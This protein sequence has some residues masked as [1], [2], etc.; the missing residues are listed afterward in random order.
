MKIVGKILKYSFFAVILFIIGFMTL[1][2]FTSGDTKTAKSFMWTER[3]VNSY[4]EAPDKFKVYVIDVPREYTEDG[5]FRISNV[6]YAESDENTAAQLQFTV[7]WNNST[8]EYLKEDFDLAEAPAG[9]P[10]I[11]TLTDDKGNVYTEYEMLSDIKPLYHYRRLA[12]DIS[13]LR[14][15]EYFR[16]NIYYYNTYDSESAA[17]T[18]DGDS[19]AYGTMIVYRKSKML[20]EYSLKKNELPKAE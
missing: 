14:D 15:A 8:I 19:G 13:D 3:T 17:D 7:R 12:F 9:E 16:L 2:I 5:K 4:R 1:R 20:F 11:F 10:F 6:R 18:E